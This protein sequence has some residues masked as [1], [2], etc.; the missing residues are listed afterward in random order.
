MRRK[1]HLTEDLHTHTGATVRIGNKF[2]NRFSTTFGVRQ[3]CIL[4]RPLFL[5][6]IDWIIGHPAPDVG[7]LMLTMLPSLCLIS[8]K[9]T[10]SS[11]QLMPSLLHCA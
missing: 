9:Q 2:S 10:M 7:M 6:A 4:D 1:A 5:V 3:G 8:F 11:N